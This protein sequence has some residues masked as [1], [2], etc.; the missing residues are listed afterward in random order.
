MA[1]SLKTMNALLGKKLSLSIE[2]IQFVGLEAKTKHVH[3]HIAHERIDTL[4]FTGM[5]SYM[6]KLTT[7]KVVYE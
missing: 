2:K 3:L 6:V 5:V 4:R 7:T 1:V